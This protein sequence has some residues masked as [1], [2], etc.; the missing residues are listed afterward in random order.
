[1]VGEGDRAAILFVVQRTDCEGFQAAADCDPAFAAALERVV[2]NGVELYVYGCEISPTGIKL[3]S[4]IARSRAEAADGDD[5]GSPRHGER[6]ST[7]VSLA[8]LRPGD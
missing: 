3:A 1:M 4:R 8:R 2:A 7:I 5:S 6:H